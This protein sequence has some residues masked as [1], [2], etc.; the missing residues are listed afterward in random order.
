MFASVFELLLFSVLRLLVS[1]FRSCSR[2]ACV[3]GDE[4]RGRKRFNVR[5]RPLA[6]TRHTAH[7]RT[8]EGRGVSALL[9]CFATNLTRHGGGGGGGGRT[10]GVY[11]DIYNINKEAYDKTLDTTGETQEVEDDAVSEGEESDV[12]VEF[13]E[14]SFKRFLA[15]FCYTQGM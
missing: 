3:V 10:Q 13:V 12:S 6:L 1:R 5:A 4:H 8:V 9:P 2:F 14:A 15:S 11:G 7:T